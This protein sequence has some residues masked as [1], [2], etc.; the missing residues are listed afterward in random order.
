[1]S[2]IFLSVCLSFLLLSGFVLYYSYADRVISLKF[3]L[4]STYSSLATYSTFHFPCITLLA[5][6]Y[7]SAQWLRSDSVLI[8]FFRQYPLSTVFRPHPNFYFDIM[9]SAGVFL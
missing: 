2:L 6:T 5:I 4:L 9:L 3:L 1:M 7:L 8:E